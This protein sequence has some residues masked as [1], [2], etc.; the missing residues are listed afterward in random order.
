[1]CEKEEERHTAGD[2]MSRILFRA[3]LVPEGI[4][5]HPWGSIDFV[6]KY[7]QLPLR[8]IIQ[9]CGFASVAVILYLPIKSK[10]VEATVL[11]HTESTC[12]F[13]EG[14]RDYSMTLFRLFDNSWV[15]VVSP[16]LDTLCQ[17]TQTPPTHTR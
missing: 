5:R 2:H 15:V 7:C 3:K 10:L 8:W 13:D 14:G 1:M 6:D 17:R 12:L 16:T 9:S 11:A 4:Q